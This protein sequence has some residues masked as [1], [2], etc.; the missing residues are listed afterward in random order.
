MAVTSSSAV[1]GIGYADA[2]SELQPT[3]KSLGQQDFL[4]LLVTQ[5]TSQDPLDPMK[6]T[7]FISQMAQ[8]SSLEQ[9]QAMQA[10]LAQLCQ[11]EQW[12]QANDL[13]GRN[14]ELQADSGTAVTGVVSAV[15]LED[16]VPK[17]VVNNT[18]FDLGAILSVSAPEAP[19]ARLLGLP[20]T[21]GAAGLSTLSDLSKNLKTL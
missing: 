3:V 12:S 20:I 15:T 4:E 19:K 14:V 6:D 7:E 17:I 5:L 9:T 13:I 16:G 18:P 11:A 1:T 21:K 2:Q 8:F 10:D